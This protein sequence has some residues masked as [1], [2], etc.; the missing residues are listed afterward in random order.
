MKVNCHVYCPSFVGE[1][2]EGEK[3]HG[4]VILLDSI[5]F[6]INF[7]FKQSLKTCF[8]KNCVK[9]NLI[10]CL[11]KIKPQILTQKKKKKKKNSF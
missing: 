3:T 2:E 10:S 9:K 5:K 6:P 8:S 4:N 1:R 7:L 11:N